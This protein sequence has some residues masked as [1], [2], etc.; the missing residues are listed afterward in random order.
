MTDEDA[1]FLTYGYTIHVIILS[2]FALLVPS[3]CGFATKTS[4]III[5]DKDRKNHL[6]HSVSGCV[7]FSKPLYEFSNP[8]VDGCGWLVG[9]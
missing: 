1:K 3:F 9:Q 7:V 4:N 8:L 5:Y 6:S 2:V